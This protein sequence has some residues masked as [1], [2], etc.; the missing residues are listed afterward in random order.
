MFRMNPD[1]GESDELVIVSLCG[2]L[3]LVYAAMVAA[4]LR[5]LAARDRWTIVDL[6]GLDFIDA[7]GATALSRGRRQAR[8]A[9][10]GLLLAAPQPR[11]QRVLSLI[12]A[13]NSSEIQA[14][15]AAAVAIAGSIPTDGC[16]DRAAVPITI[17]RSPRWPG[18]YP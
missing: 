11:V 15:V 13:A 7:A 8:N 4:A 1:S 18:R 6:S 3:D 17:T 5:F 2:E 12:W 14:S 10:G 9:G 16:A